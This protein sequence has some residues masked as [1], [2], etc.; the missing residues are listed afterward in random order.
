MDKSNGQVGRTTGNPSSGEQGAATRTA[1]IQAA[2]ALIGE[3]GWGVVTTRAIAERAGVPHG[4][5]SYHFAGKRELLRSAAAAAIAEIFAGP[6]ALAREAGGLEQL[7]EGTL[8]WYRAGG[9]NDPSV[10]VLM[11]VL[12]EAVRDEPLRELI[13]R[14]NGD[15]RVAVADLVRRDRERGL[16][17]A[18]PSTAASPEGLAAVVAALFDGLLLHLLIDPELDLRETIAAIDVLLLGER[19]TDD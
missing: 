8:S 5:V 11:E 18:A 9:V 17:G 16:P 7:L 4:A 6:I 13:A 12:R 3:V 2:T 15:Y 10:G 1:I 19:R 14:E